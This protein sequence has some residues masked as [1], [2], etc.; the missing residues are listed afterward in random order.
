MAGVRKPR[1]PHRAHAKALATITQAQFMIGIYGEIVAMD[2]V[3]I[4]R[5][6]QLLMSPSDHNEATTLANLQLVL[7]QLEKVGERLSYWNDRVHELAEGSPGQRN[8]DGQT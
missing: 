4:E 2:Q 7:A 1:P 3:I 5:V 6:R 8:G